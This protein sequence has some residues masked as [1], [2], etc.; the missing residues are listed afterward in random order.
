M[1]ESACDD[2]KKRCDASSTY[3]RADGRG[4]LERQ[5]GAGNRQPSGGGLMRRYRKAG[6]AGLL[7]DGK[8]ERECLADWTALRQLVGRTRSVTAF[9]FRACLDL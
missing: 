9:P 6:T 5:T 4:K 7:A 1:T 2:E 3:K 8:Y